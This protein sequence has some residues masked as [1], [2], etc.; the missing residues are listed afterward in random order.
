MSPLYSDDVLYFIS[1]CRKDGEQLASK[2]AD[3]LRLLTRERNV[4]RDVVNVEVGDDAQKDIDENLKI[5]DVLIFLQ[6]GNAQYSKYIMKELC[7]AMLND[8]PILW[9]QIDNAPYE[10]MEIRPCENPVL[11][12]DSDEFSI[13]SGWK[14]L[15]MK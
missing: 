6:T 7:H 9:I 3:G 1:H 14:R 10:D 15:W 13:R 8:I 11:R 5:S 4:Y 2:L 12:Y